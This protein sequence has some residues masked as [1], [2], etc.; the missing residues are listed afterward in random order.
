MGV[1]YQDLDVRVAQLARMVEFV[2]KAF[3]VVDPTNPFSKPRTLLDE[4]YK[5]LSTPAVYIT[6]SVKDAEVVVEN[7]ST[8]VPLPTTEQAN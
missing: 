6:D 7:P 5:S 1:S 3:A 4:Y 2:M 8:D